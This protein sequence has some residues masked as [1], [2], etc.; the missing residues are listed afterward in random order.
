M[1]SNWWDGKLMLGIFDDG[2][3]AASAGDGSGSSTAG[4]T[5]ADAGQHPTET[6]AVNSKGKPNRDLS[7]VRYGKQ[8]ETPQKNID[9][10]TDDMEMAATEKP[11]NTSFD[12]LI[13]GEYKEDFQK[14]TQ[15]I[16]DHRFKEAKLAEERLEALAP[17]LDLLASR[18]GVKKGD[19]TALA[20]AI[21]EDNAFYEQEAEEQ[22]ITVE[23]LKKQ[24]KLE[25]ENAQLRAERQRAESDR[26]SQEIYNGWLGQAEEVKTVYPDFDF[27]KECENEKFVELIKYPAIDVK[28]AYEVIHRDEIL[29]GA[30]QHTAHT[31]QQ[32]TVEDIKA[33]G[34]RP[35]ENGTKIQS[36][37]ILKTDVN[38]LTKEDMAEINRRVARGEKIV[39]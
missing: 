25:Q 3:G 34:L 32:K 27:A 7:K 31:I 22:G 36:P 5:A 6:P 9:V 19:H 26:R 38:E 29:A 33:R 28:T 20:R 16:I 12:E 1:Q 4:T 17:V 30:M 39:F 10:K 8:P 24:K 2:A 14:R 11:E 21:E 23:Q 35:P 13:K 37:A 18:Y 15:A